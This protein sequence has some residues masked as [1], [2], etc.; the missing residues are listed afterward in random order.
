MTRRLFLPIIAALSLDSLPAADEGA[1][2]QDPAAAFTVMLENATLNGS[3]API[4]KGLLGDEKKDR[5]HIVKTRPKE[6]DTWEIFYKMKI[7][8]REI[9]YPIPVTIKFAGDTAVMILNNSPVGV[10]Q[11]W[12]ARILF[13]DDVYAGSWWNKGKTK[14]GIVSGTITR[15]TTK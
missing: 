5:Y 8:G 3:W 14:G 4:D 2:T 6:G 1:N 12:S 11:T 13:H 7:Q 15:A 9:V 10:G